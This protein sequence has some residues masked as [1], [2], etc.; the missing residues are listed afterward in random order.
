MKHLFLALALTLVGSP[1]F[2]QAEA[3]IVLREGLTNGKTITFMPPAPE[4]VKAMVARDGGIFRRIYTYE[5]ES[6]RRFYLRQKLRGVKDVRP[7]EVQHPGWHKIQEGFKRWNPVVSGGTDAAL[8]YFAV[9]G[10]KK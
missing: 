4:P 7:Y 6:G 2:A 10:A 8:G 1:A 3:D 5:T 9:T